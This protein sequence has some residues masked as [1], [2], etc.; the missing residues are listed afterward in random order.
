MIT[1]EHCKK[2]ECCGAVQAPKQNFS[3]NMFIRASIKEIG[4]HTAK[5]GRSHENGD[6]AEHGGP[7]TRDLKK[8]SGI[9]RKRKNGFA[10][11]EELEP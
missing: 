3:V 7:R 11:L 10:F 8:T 9:A 4:H 6:C 2:K 5:C 1:D